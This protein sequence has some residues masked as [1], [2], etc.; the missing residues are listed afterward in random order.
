MNARICCS[1]RAKHVADAIGRDSPIAQSRP[2]R[3]A[4]TWYKAANVTR[5][6]QTETRAVMVPDWTELNSLEKV[7]MRTPRGVDCA[8]TSHEIN[9]L[10]KKQKQSRGRVRYGDS[11]RKNSTCSP[12]ARP[13]TNSDLLPAIYDGD[14]IGVWSVPGMPPPALFHKDERSP[15]I[16]D[17]QHNPDQDTKA[18]RQPFGVSVEAVA[19]EGLVV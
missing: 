14:A 4:S 18:Q 2:L 17:G 16:G 13:G 12:T 19:D 3:A 8:A 1:R 5:S 11:V 6:T 15:Q 9:G 7:K 10:G